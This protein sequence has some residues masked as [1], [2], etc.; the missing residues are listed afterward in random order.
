MFVDMADRKMIGVSYVVMFLLSCISLKS[1]WFFLHGGYSFLWFAFVYF[2]GATM[3]KY[4]VM[5]KLSVVKCLLLLCAVLLITWVP[6]MTYLFYQSD[7]LAKDIQ[8]GLISYASPTVLF[9][10]MLIL[11]LFQRIRIN[12][13]ISKFITF[14]STSAFSVYLIHDNKHIRSMCIE[15]RFA[16]LNEQNPFVMVGVVLLCVL[17]IYLVCTLVEKH[18]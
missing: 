14:F 9:M 6:K 1:D 12:A 18:I 10:A 13:I 15:E 16:F 4:Q 7:G 8:N 17:V 2:I 3:K 11:A 5:Q